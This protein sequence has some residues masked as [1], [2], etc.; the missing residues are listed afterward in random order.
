M[1]AVAAPCVHVAGVSTHQPL[2]IPEEESSS[3]FKKYS[4]ILHNEVWQAYR[5][6]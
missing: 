3:Q 2:D 5:L 6:D 4:S 1:T